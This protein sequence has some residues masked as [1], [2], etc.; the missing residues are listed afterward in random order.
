MGLSEWDIN[1]EEFTRIGYIVKGEPDSDAS[2][3]VERCLHAVLLCHDVSVRFRCDIA[4]VRFRC[5]IAFMRFRC[6]IAFV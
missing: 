3:F 5:D 1:L 6:D 4:F 2:L